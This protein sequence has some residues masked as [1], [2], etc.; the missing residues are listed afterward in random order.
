M[1]VAV[2]ALPRTAVGGGTT[3]KP[4]MGKSLLTETEFQGEIFF[5]GVESI[6][7]VQLQFSTI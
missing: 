2:S 5:R 6:A 1:S 7:I 3:E 4:F